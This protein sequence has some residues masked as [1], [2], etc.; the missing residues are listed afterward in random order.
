MTST[1]PIADMFTRIRNAAAVNSSVIVL[2]HSQIKEKVAKILV[3][4]GFINAVQA[5]DD[6]SRRILE[7]RIAPEGSNSLITEIKRISTPGRRVYV[8]SPKIPQVKRGRG[9]VIISTS[10]GLM[11]GEE[12]RNKKLGGEVIAE[13]Y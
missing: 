1:D 8:K 3:D 12:A 13:V 11:T 6:A 10:H 5:K 4:N 7:I 9:I 2:P